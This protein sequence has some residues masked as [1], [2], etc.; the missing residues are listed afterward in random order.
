MNHLLACLPGIS[1]LSSGSSS[2]TAAD[3]STFPAH[4]NTK[5]AKG[6]L[7]VQL[8]VKL[9]TERQVGNAPTARASAKAGI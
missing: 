3:V 9:P 7:S 6:R 5:L 4:F 2:P 1:L 8:P